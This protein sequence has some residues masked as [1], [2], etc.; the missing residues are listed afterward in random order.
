V[1]PNQKNKIS[2]SLKKVPFT[3]K[4]KKQLNDARKKRKFDLDTRIKMSDSS[5]KKWEN[6]EYRKHML[7]N[8]KGLFIKNDKPWNKGKKM[9]YI[10]GML[11]KKHTEKTIIK[12]SKAQKG[13]KKP[14]FT[15]E[16]KRHLKENHKGML[17]KKVSEK[18][19]RKMSKAHEGNKCFWF[20]KKMTLA[21]R[22]VLSKAHLGYKPTKEH[23]RKILKKRLKSS[24]EIK[25]ENIINKNKLPY[26]FVGNGEFF[27]ERKNPDFVNIN[28]EKKAI[29]VYYTAHKEKFRKMNI[30]Q[31][32]K[33]RSDIF[34]KY[35]WK[36]IFFNET[37]VNEFN[38]IKTLKGG[39]SKF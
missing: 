13:K 34:S 38:I 37:Q 36:L 17:G 11:G 3:N 18:T 26:K 29:E 12:M 20:G 30:D 8:N 1:L 31:W 9:T 14:P 7:E 6:K 39:A 10:N 32:K 5:K 19:K 25:F 24:L 27:V 15:E 16:H 28:G 2:Q 35:G 22:K 4:R 21:Q 33:T 23:I